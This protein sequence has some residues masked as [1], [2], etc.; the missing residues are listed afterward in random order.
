METVACPLCGGSDWMPVVEAEDHDAAPPRSKFSV[1]RCRSCGLCVTNPR[2]APA[3]IGKFY[4]ADYSPYKIAERKKSR[5][6]GIKSRVPHSLSVFPRN[7]EHGEFPP[8]GQ[9]RV[10]D[11]GCGGGAFLLRMEE[12]GWDVTGL[13]F[14][15]ATVER[16]RAEL[17]LHVLE[18]TLPHPDLTPESFDL[19]TLW[20][21]LEHVH[22]PLD[23]LREAHRLL[24]PGGRVLVALPNIESLSFVW[25]GPDWYG[26]DVPRHVTHFSPT[27]LRRMLQ[28]AGFR[29]QL[30]QNIRHSLWF[31]NSVER[32]RHNGRLRWPGTWMQ[33][34]LA[35]SF[36]T[37]YQQTLC[38]ADSFLMIAEKIGR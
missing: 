2:P 8:I 13:D 20:H 34:K 19:I 32:A 37:R 29:V 38:R 14:S 18:G 27:T 23:V 3:E 26:L 17:G 9:N 31:R 4:A 35:S 10:L 1:V 15:K 5:R 7:Y 21:S 28:K 25:F 11:F 33:S 30:R 24:S 16:L 6:N 12:R 36:L 22:Q